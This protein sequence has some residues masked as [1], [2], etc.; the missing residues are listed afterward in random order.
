APSAGTHLSFK[1]LKRVTLKSKL[2]EN[3][4]RNR[5]KC[6]WGP[7]IPPRREDPPFGTG[8]LAPPGFAKM[9][10]NRDERVEDSV[11]FVFETSLQVFLIWR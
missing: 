7:S 10:M 11:I 2:E 6:V 4:Q 9:V 3:L 5:L 1:N 8:G